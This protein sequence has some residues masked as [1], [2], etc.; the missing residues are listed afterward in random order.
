MA[1]ESKGKGKNMEVGKRPGPGSTHE[2]FGGN[3]GDVGIGGGTMHMFGHR[4]M[5]SGVWPGNPVSVDQ[6]TGYPQGWD[7]KSMGPKAGKN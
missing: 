4:K 5:E 6:K 1:K 3:P 7:G 2:S